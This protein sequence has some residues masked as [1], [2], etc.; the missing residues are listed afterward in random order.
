[1]WIFTEREIYI[2]VYIKTCKCR[3]SPTPPGDEI[4]LAPFGSLAKT[5]PAR[6]ESETCLE[7]NGTCGINTGNSLKEKFEAASVIQMKEP[8]YHSSFCGSIQCRTHGLQKTRISC[9]E[10]NVRSRAYPLN[11]GD[12]WCVRCTFLEFC[13]GV[14]VF[15]YQSLLRGYICTYIYMCVCVDH[16][17]RCKTSKRWFGCFVSTDSFFQ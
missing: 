16:L 5:I 2:Y 17:K 1:M 9:R 13:C 10:V 6:Y 12:L 8:S 15:C 7:D 11:T 14:Y 4:G 3:N